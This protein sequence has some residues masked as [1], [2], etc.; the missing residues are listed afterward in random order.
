MNLSTKALFSAAVLAFAV[1]A[2]A[3]PSQAQIFGG[4]GIKVTGNITQ[5]VDARQ[6]RTSGEAKVNAAIIKGNV[7]ARNISQR[8]TL[9]N[10]RASGNSEQN[11]AVIDGTN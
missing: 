10:I 6:V 7:Q 1:A 3:A 9:R 11:Y 5:A 2:G 4:G 8:V